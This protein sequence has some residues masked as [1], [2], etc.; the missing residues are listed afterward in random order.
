[1]AGSS[2]VR[3]LIVTRLNVL[4]LCLASHS[5]QNVAVAR[6]AYLLAVEDYRSP[7]FDAT[8]YCHRDAELLRDTLTRSLDYPD[9][10]VVVKLLGKSNV[11][12]PAAVLEDLEA[13]L[14][15]SGPEDTILFYFAGHG[16]LSG[17]TGYLLLP[18]SNSEDYATT[19]LSLDAIDSLLRRDERL[20]I[21]VFDACHSG[22]E[23][24]KSRG[25]LAL[26]NSGFMNVLQKVAPRGWVTFASCEGDQKSFW[27]EGERHGAF[28]MAFCAAISSHREGQELTVLALQQSVI[29]RMERWTTENGKVQTPVLMGV[30]PGSQGIGIRTT[31]RRKTVITKSIEPSIADRLA[32]VRKLPVPTK[33]ELAVIA[34][35]L[36]EGL[37]VVAPEIEAFG[38]E[39]Y[40][41]TFT[42][43]R[44]LGSALKRAVVED[45]EG[46]QLMPSFACNSE[47]VRGTGGFLLDV[48][49][50]RDM[51]KVFTFSPGEG[52]CVFGELGVDGVHPLPGGS[53]VTVAFALQTKFYVVSGSVVQTSHLLPENRLGL[54]L[55]FYKL[56]EPS[57]AGDWDAEG[58]LRQTVGNFNSRYKV[59]ASQIAG[60]L[61]RESS[62]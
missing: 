46:K 35:L 20:C 47:L 59:V 3:W 38:A 49:S 18:L 53:I 26:D 56:L 55:H 42:D 40:G 48:F 14:K 7:D 22:L 15:K 5:G 11:L 45:V 31:R 23:P 4:L 44:S 32:D 52:Q 28:T 6:F 34:R 12:E 43:G 13:L 10:Q 41:P 51:Q 30:I 29:A 25:G 61:E 19:A 58:H 54:R 9:D 27:D 60:Y 50:P 1:M 39:T 57:E 33:D 24:M 16:T 36:K 17:Q 37:A 21:R 62:L 8:P 2:F